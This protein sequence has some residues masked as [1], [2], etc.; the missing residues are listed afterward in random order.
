[1]TIPPL[2]REVLVDADRTLAFAVFTQRIGAWWPV[3][4]HSVHGAG[5]TVV[6]DAEEVGGRLVESKAGADDAVWGT[7]TRWEPVD[8]VAF[9]WHPGQGPE[10]ASQVSVTFEDSGGKTLVRLEH[11]GWEAFGERAQEA[12]E[13]YDHGW[14]VVLDAYAALASAAA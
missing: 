13:E 12:R 14:P 7:V 6:F 8:A 2:R 4:V 9:T 5:A 11:T 3:D 10:R 1:M